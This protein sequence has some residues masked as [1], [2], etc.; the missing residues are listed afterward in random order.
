ITEGGDFEQ[1]KRWTSLLQARLDETYPEAYR[2]INK[3][4][5]GNTSAQGFDR[6]CDDVLPYFP[7]LLLVEFGFNDANVKDWTIEPRVSLEEFVRNLREFHRI[8]TAKNTCCVFILNH[9]IAD[10]GGRQGN[11][12][13]YN[14]N[15]LPYDQAVITLA[16]ELKAK[17]IDLP[18]MMIAKETPLNEYLSD[19]NLHLSEAGNKHYAQ[20]VFDVIIE[21]NFYQPI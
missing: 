3:G 2:V 15:L 18:G 9:S 20:M 10:V 1:A 17:V 12:L 11:G 14:Q 4:I 19:D 13:T 6:F 16:E 7:G 5:S 21:N 8:A